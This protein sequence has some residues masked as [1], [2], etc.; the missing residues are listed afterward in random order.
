VIAEEGRTS[1][2]LLEAIVLEIFLTPFL[3]R[4]MRSRT[5]LPFFSDFN[6]MSV[7]SR[8]RSHLNDLI[9]AHGLVRTHR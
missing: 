6:S 8:S 2:R 3:R 5:R 7:C 1:E 4:A 9:H